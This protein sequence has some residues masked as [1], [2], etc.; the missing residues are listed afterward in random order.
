MPTL[1]HYDQTHD[2]SAQTGVPAGVSD[3]E[4]LRQALEGSECAQ[5]EMRSRLLEHYFA[6][7]SVGVGP[8]AE[9]AG[10]EGKTQLCVL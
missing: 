10:G 4:A 6:S 8:D 9:G 1:L 7:E 2:D 5:S 3:Q